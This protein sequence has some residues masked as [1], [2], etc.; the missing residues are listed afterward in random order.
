VTFLDAPKQP[1]TATEASKE[2][3]EE[4][5]LPRWGEA[6]VAA[7]KAVLAQPDID[8]S[9]VLV[10]GHSEGGIVAARVAAELPKVTHVAPLGCGGATQLYSLVELA[11]RRAPEG[12]GV[13]AMERVYADWAK[14]QAKPESIEDFWMAH[15]YRRWS[16]FLKHSVIEELKRS[17][18]K[19]YLA[20]GTAD[21]ADAV[22]GFDMM[23]AELLAHG[24]DVT[25]ERIEGGDHGFSTSGP[26]GQADGMQKVFGNVIEWFL[27]K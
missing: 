14:I 26:K 11:R 10:T 3:L 6:N 5:T 13:A 16:S 8:G 7:L 9:R 12:Q 25:A 24:R 20:H 21:E 23:R 2:Y 4:H 18:A 19:I 22:Q 17:K 27:P 1:G 15:P